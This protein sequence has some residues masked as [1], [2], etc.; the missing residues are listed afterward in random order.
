MSGQ[1][2]T[3]EK[4]K[5]LVMTSFVYFVTVGRNP[6]GNHRPTGKWKS[7]TVRFKTSWTFIVAAAGK[8]RPIFFSKT[9]VKS[10]KES[11][12]DFTRLLFKQNKWCSIVHNS[13]IERDFIGVIK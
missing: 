4:I 9:A 6:V 13:Y 5:K 8:L 2:D 12:I 3:S 7:N 10:T 1:A 11:T